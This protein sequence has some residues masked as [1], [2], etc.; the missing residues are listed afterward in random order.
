MSGGLEWG[1]GMNTEKVASAGSLD[2]GLKVLE[3]CD[4]GRHRVCRK[5]EDKCMC[6]LWVG[7]KSG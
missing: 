3:D 5:L 1:Y 2:G 6:G 4:D 7:F